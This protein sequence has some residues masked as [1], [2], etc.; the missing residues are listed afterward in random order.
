[1]K[2]VVTG[3][4]GAARAGDLAAALGRSGLSRD[5]LLR[6][7]PSATERELGWAAT[8]QPLEALDAARRTP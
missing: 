1:M 3:V 4:S 6:F 5:W 7:D 2:I 8:R